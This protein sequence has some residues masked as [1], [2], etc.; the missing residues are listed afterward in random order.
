MVFV[1][2]L[3]GSWKIEEQVIEHELKD[4]PVA[5]TDKE[6]A[7]ILRLSPRKIWSMG[8]SGEIRRIQSGKSVRYDVRGY[9]EKRRREEE[10]GDGSDL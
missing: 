6:A 7:E 3:G 2:M 1:Y 4:I 9:I 8:M 10:D 5:A